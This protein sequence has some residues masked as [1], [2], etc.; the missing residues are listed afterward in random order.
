MRIRYYKPFNPNQLYSLG[1]P[2]DPTD[3]QGLAA[4]STSTLQGLI[5]G[6]YEQLN[7]EYPSLEAADWYNALRDVLRERD[8][9]PGVLERPA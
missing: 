2:T 4:L 6:V 9:G 3:A 5:N 7:S 1:L 8:S